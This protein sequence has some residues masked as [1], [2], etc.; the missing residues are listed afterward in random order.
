MDE[1][2][3][4]GWSRP[5]TSRLSTPLPW[6]WALPNSEMLVPLLHHVT[7]LGA[8]LVMVNNIRMLAIAHPILPI[9]DW[10]LIALRAS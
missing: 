8:W 3:G 4:L 9:T 10:E 5:G 1:V 7:V 6:R 2:V